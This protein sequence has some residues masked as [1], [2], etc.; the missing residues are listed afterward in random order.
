MHPDSQK[1]QLEARLMRDSETYEQSYAGNNSSVTPYQIQFRFLDADDLAVVVT[2]SAGMSMILT[3]GDYTITRDAV[4]ELGSF[5][6]TDAVPVT[7]TVK[8]YRDNALKQ[9]LDYVNSDTFPADSHE[10]GMD[11]LTEAIQAVKGIALRAMRVSPGDSELTFEATGSPPNTVAGLDDD[12]DFIF[13][14][15]AELLSFL[16]LTEPVIN[17]P[18]KTWA[19]NGERALAVPDFLGQVG[20][21]LDTGALYV[22]TGLSAGNW[23]AS[24]ASTV[25]DLSITREKLAD[26]ALTADVLGRAKMADAF[27]TLAKMNVDF[28]TAMT[29]KT[30][31]ES[32]DYL[33]GWSATDNAFRKFAGNVADP[34]GSVIQTISA[35]PYTANT[36]ITT[37]LSLS[38]TVPQ[39]TQG[40]QILTLT[41]TPRFATSQIRL[42]FNGFGTGSLAFWLI[43]AL[44]R[45]P[46]T[47]AIYTATSA[48]AAAG[49]GQQVTID[50]IDSPATT[51][52]TTYTI[53]VGPNTAMTLRMNGSSA[54]RFFGGS[55]ACTLVAQEIKV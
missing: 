20:V 13:R 23:A 2:D 48:S 16:S 18:T 15:S 44:F 42:T 8:V 10:A 41:I 38:D 53:R 1:R 54:A 30:L 7:S 55:A 17:Q 4:T 40:T 33:A 9:Q 45:S 43:A 29:A 51:S 21:Q 19:N 26:G 39:I 50:W 11:R 32:G 37:A 31:L 3:T 22:S 52:A 28:V 14:S 36:N 6:T 12:G 34:A 25:S 35:T 5:V 47:N 27:I 46:V 49:N 24:V